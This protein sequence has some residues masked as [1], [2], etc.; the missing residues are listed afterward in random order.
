MP[1]LKKVI[2]KIACFGF[3]RSAISFHPFPIGVTDGY[4]GSG[5]EQH[6]HSCD[7]DHRRVVPPRIFCYCLGAICDFDVDAIVHLVGQVE[8]E[9]NADLRAGIE[10]CYPSLG[11]RILGMK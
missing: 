10:V 3:L 7:R 6:R 8:E 4:K 2:L 1:G 5:E 9:I 11:A